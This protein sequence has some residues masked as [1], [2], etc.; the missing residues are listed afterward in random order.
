MCIIWFKCLN[1]V[2]ALSV[3]ESCDNVLKDV[4]KFKASFKLRKRSSSQLEI[5]GKFLSE[6]TITNEEFEIARQ[7]DHDY[8]RNRIFEE[9]GKLKHAIEALGDDMQTAI[10]LLMNPSATESGGIASYFQVIRRILHIADHQPVVV[11]FYLP[12]LM[13]VRIP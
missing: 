1:Y 4:N 10:S 7:L 9:A 6:G 2:H 8:R 12:Q 3:H 13:Q 5:A 11:D